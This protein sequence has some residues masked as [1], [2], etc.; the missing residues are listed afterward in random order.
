MRSFRLFSASLAITLLVAAVACAPAA[1]NV[2][3]NISGA[4]VRAS[5]GTDNPTAGYMTISNTG[6]TADAL[7]AATADAAGRVEI[8][9]TMPGASGMHAMEP[10]SEINVPAGGTV[11]LEPGGFHLMLFELAA[12]LA[13]GDEVLLSLTFANAGTIVVPADVRAP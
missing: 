6:N 12:P 8:H 10:V 5:M 1:P 4:W 11:T 9:R 2:Q 3:L 13:A 7:I